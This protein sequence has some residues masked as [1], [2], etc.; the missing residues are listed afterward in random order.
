MDRR[1][2]LGIEADIDAL[3]VSGRAATVGPGELYQIGGGLPVPFI[4]YENIVASA[5]ER[6]SLRWLSTVRARVGLPVTADRGLLYLTGGLALGGVSS[7]GSV[8]IVNDCC[9]VAWGGSNSSTR[10]GYTVGGGFEYALTD[11][12]TT[13]VEYLYYNL[14][15]A[16]H[17][18]NLD[19]IAG[20]A[21]LAYPTLGNTV[22]PIH[23]TIVR[24]GFNYKFGGTQPL[25]ANM[26]VKAPPAPVPAYSWE[27]FYLG[28]NIGYGRSEAD[29]YFNSAPVTVY[30]SNTFQLGVPGFVASEAVKP[31]GLIGGGQIGSG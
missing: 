30:P 20:P 23:G 17:A 26:V 7:S 18:L 2:V 11:H 19:D 4:G 10:T 8:R 22:A 1:L 12:W 25:A 3:Q 29:T 5:S 21:G 24:T 28:G 16:T 31:K 13:K 27:G 6:V 15:N 14:G 9:L